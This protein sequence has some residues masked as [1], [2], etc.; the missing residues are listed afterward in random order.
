MTTQDINI[1]ELEISELNVREMVDGDNDT[2]PF[3]DLV[4][5]IKKHGLLNP[6][7]VKLNNETN[8]YE[9]IAGQRRFNALKELKKE[10]IKCSV[11]DGNTTKEQQIILSLTE[12]IHRQNM[13]LSDLIK[14]CKKISVY[15][16]ME[17]P[18]E[19]EKTD[20]NIKATIK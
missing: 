20:K 16:K 7:L 9:I 17:K 1:D 18:E 2:E 4:E 15:Y 11:I 12:N 19:K 13:K 14:T 5:N 6:L 10:V 3:K 8:K